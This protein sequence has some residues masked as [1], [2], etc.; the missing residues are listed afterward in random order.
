MTLFMYTIT[1]IIGTQC[2]NN[3][4]IETS[5]G[6]TEVMYCLRSHMHD[7]CAHSYTTPIKNGSI[8]SSCKCTELG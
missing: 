4:M 8:A 5:F 6:D 7:V 1:S 2:H 3:T